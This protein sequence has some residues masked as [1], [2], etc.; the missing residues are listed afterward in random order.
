MRYR[1]RTLVLLTAIVPP[2]LAALW[3][4]G[5]SAFVFWIMPKNM[6]WAIVIGITN[7]L[8]S[9]LIAALAQWWWAACVARRP[10]HSK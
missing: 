6:G 7:G 9:M 4:W 1:L 2:L 5:L 10:K 8:G 3:F